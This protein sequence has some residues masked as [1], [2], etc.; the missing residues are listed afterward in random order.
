MAIGCLPTARG[1]ASGK[2]PVAS[3]GRINRT[4][5]G[6][7]HV[8][9]NANGPFDRAQ[10]KRAHLHPGVFAALTC[11]AG[12]RHAAPVAYGRTYYHSGVFAALTLSPAHPHIFS[13]PRPTTR[14]TGVPA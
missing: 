5:N 6:K 2:Q 12:H 4:A 8:A 13:L 3:N 10:C 9:G 1:V 11:P 7:Q 14:Q